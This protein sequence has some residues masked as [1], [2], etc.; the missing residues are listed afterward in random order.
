M[1]GPF[2]L[3]AHHDKKNNRVIVTDGFV[4]SPE[5]PD[6]RDKIRQM[7]AIMHTLQFK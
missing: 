3:Q 6:K 5:K 7:E 1:G 2:V 4:Y